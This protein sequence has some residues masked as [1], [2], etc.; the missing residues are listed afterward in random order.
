MSF[1]DSI[2]FHDEDKRRRRYILPKQIPLIKGDVT[3]P[4]RLLICKYQQV[5]LMKKDYTRLIRRDDSP[6]GILLD[7]GFE[8]HGGV[9]IM[10]ALPPDSGMYVQ[11]VR[12]RL[13]E[14]AIEA[15]TPVPEKNATNEHS[16]RDVILPISTLADIEFG[17]SG[18]RFVYIEPLETDVELPLVSVQG[19]F[20]YSD[21]KYIGSF[22]CDDDEINRIYETAVYTCHLNLQKYIWDGIKR[23]RLVWLGDMHPEVKTLLAVFGDLPEI[24]AS[25]KFGAEEAPLPGWIDGIPAYS[26]WWLIILRDY[27]FATDNREPL[28]GLAEYAENLSKQIAGF[29][30]KNGEHS[31]P[32]YFLDWPT[33]NTPGAFAGVHALL[34]MAL[35]AAEEL[36]MWLKKIDTA[37]ICRTA[38]RRLMSYPVPDASGYKQSLAML[39]LSGLV[40]QKA[41]AIQLA[42]GGAAGMSTFMSYY[43]LSS[44][45]GGGLPGDALTILKEYYGGMLKAGATTFFEDFDIGWVNNAVPI[46]GLPDEK[47]PS[48]HADNGRYC[49]LGLRHSLCHGWSSGPVSFLAEQVLGIK[50]LEP[51]GKTV[52]IAPSLGHLREASGHFPTAYGTLEVSH[53]RMPDGSVRTIC[54]VPDDVRI[55]YRSGT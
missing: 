34:L 19:V 47:K 31:L 1:I 26:M 55:E 45:S 2:T 7:F 5:S 35:R 38:V 28:F 44:L 39:S 41:A 48:L 33:K 52:L 42:K 8:F 54:R 18:L 53:K 50:F 12:I 21:R 15:L 20:I 11:N 22:S 32:D 16:P 43:I 17:Q 36:M 40:D 49:Y 27:T 24:A 10:T 6:A 13:G 23:D 9:R 29:I 4:E 37:D 30:G 14:S 51:G 46:D 3:N 25:L